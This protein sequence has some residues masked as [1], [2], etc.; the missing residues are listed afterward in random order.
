MVGEVIPNSRATVGSKMRQ[1]LYGGGASAFAAYGIAGAAYATSSGASKDRRMTFAEDGNLR[2]G[3]KHTLAAMQEQASGQF[4]GAD[5]SVLTGSGAAPAGTSAEGEA[6]LSQGAGEAYTS[7]ARITS[8]SHTG[9]GAGATV[10]S[11]TRK[12]IADSHRVMHR[13]SNSASSSA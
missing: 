1:S 11:T 3:T 2:S 7:P 6:D 4:L 12:S 5:V 10:L 9:G 8:W 13:V